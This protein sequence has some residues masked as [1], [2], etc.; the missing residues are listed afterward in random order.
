MIRMMKNILNKRK[1]K[2]KKLE[3]I[4]I[5]LIFP[6]YRLILIIM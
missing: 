4:K 2:K 6:K 3:L 5:I 1:N